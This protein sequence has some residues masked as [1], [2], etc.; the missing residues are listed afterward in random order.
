MLSHRAAFAIL[1]GIRTDIAAKLSRMPLGS[2]I[3]TPSGKLK[4]LIVDTVEKMEVPL[5]HLIP[6]LTSNLLVPLFMAAYLFWL[7][8]RIALLALATFPV[9]LFCYMA[10]TKD[11]AER[12]ATVQDAG[13]G[14]NAAIV[15]YINGIEVI[16]AFNQSSSSYEKFAKAVESFKDYTLKWYQSSWKVMNFVSAVLPSTFLG[17]LPIG[18]YLYWNGSLSPQDL[19]M[20]LILSLGI[21]GPLMNF[22]TYINET[23]AI[24]Y[25]V[26]DVDEL[27]HAEE[28]PDAE[29][30]VDIQSKDIQLQDV[31]FSYDKESG[32][33]VLSHINL[34]I[35]EGKFTALV[36]PSGGGKS[37]IARLIARFGM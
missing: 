22:T 26:H 13:K 10:M 11:Y 5:A 37:T 3:E 9:G 19:V 4:T 2:V 30:P 6:E 33:Q 34:K 28:L 20:C 16:K 17:T 29:K 27:L 7:D 21:V 24:E 35:P 8:W 18:M 23:K 36:G 15:E 31:S 25:A 1:K 32:K 12:Y 14:M